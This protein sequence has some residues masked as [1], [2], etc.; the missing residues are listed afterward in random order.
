[1]NIQIKKIIL[2]LLSVVFVA[3]IHK[4]QAQIDDSHFI[5]IQSENRKPFYVVLNEK[6]YSSSSIGYLII[7]KLK[8]GTYNFRLGFPQN[9]APEQKFVTVV[10]NNDIGYSLKEID[11]NTYALTDLQTQEVVVANGKQPSG[12]V[13]A[14]TPPKK[15]R[16][17]QPE[18]KQP[19]PEPVVVATVEEKPVVA[20]EPPVVA[21]NI[22]PVKEEPKSRTFG[23]LMSTVVNDPNLA[24]PAQK[25]APKPKRDPFEETKIVR[26]GDEKKPVETPVTQTTPQPVVSSPEV[27]AAPSDTYG[28]IRTE[29]KNVNN[30]REMSFVLLSNTSTDSVK[31]FIPSD[32]PQPAEAA[33]S[34]GT[35]VAV[36]PP[37]AEEKKKSI[38]YFDYEDLAQQAPPA[39]E[40][41]T[42]RNRN[43]RFIK[44]EEKPAAPANQVENP[45]YTNEPKV[46]PAEE[47]VVEATEVVADV[48]A[49]NYNNCSGGEIADRDFNK[50]RNKMIGRDNDDD[51]VTTAMDMLGK[52]CITTAKVKTLAGLF[53]TD[54]GRLRFFKAVYGHVSDKQNFAGLESLIYDKAKKAEFRNSVK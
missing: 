11:K 41:K 33:V 43:E 21:A 17:E 23:D 52:K 34:T 20:E 50:I 2:L 37:P 24:K 16:E 46:A 22:T 38:A 36:Q 28:V 13:A 15:T 30:G 47:T 19:D 8:S 9:A 26:A 12:N 5:Y 44:K 4:V 39:I 48:A 18:V 7:P 42:R 53:I 49:A 25:E 1:M 51:M 14:A 45:F 31:I 40:K 27:V 10:K 32:E 6:L 29:D 3:G 54:N 35:P